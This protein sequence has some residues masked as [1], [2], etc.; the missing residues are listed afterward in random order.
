MIRITT[1]FLCMLLA[2]AA[3]GR[4]RA[5]VSVKET[6]SELRR[7][8]TNKLEEVRSIQMLRA[9]VAYLENPNRLSKIAQAKTDLRPSEREQLLTARQFAVTMNGDDI[10]LEES[11]DNAPGD[12]IKNAIA[13]AQLADTQ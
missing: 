11:D 4:Y 8:E 6:H 9:E 10:E 7:L 1:I 5:E 3:A 12:L 2:A 13:M